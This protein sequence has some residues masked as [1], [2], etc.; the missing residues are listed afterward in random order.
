M[1]SV[2]AQIASL[3][4]FLSSPRQQR[5]HDRA[6]A[7]DLAWERAGLSLP[8]GLDLEWLGTSGFRLTCEGTSILI[9]PYVSRLP[10]RDLLLRRATRPSHTA[11]A[12]H[13]GD[14][15]NAILIGHTHFDHA[16]DTPLIARRD[17]ARVYGSR[18]MRNLMGVYGLADLAVEVEPY[19]TYDI[20]PFAVTF[21]P[22]VHSK[23]VLGLRVPYPGDICCAHFDDLVPQAYACGRVYGIHIE[24][25]G[26]TFYHQG[27]AD[28]VDDAVR[29][30]GVDFFLAGIA[31]RGF[32]D[33]YTQRILRALEPRVVVP[34]HYDDFF[35]PLTGPMR[36]SFNVD[37]AGFADEVAATSRDFTVA[38]LTPTRAV[39]L[40]RGS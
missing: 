13:I 37:L 33:R 16:L 12:R 3:I 4:R 36:F 26:V 38:N 40:R 28:L 35:Q 15:V 25:A 18:S 11:I 20:G 17:R 22:S 9:D 32:T 21:V 23:L 2:P 29:H 30:R 24:V 27:S 5:E 19:V 31:G 6:V 7:A 14:P 1:P 10:V 8:P 34:H 39:G